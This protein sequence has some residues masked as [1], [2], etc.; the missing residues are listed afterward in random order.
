MNEKLIGELIAYRAK[1]FKENAQSAENVFKFFLDVLLRHSE[2]R[3]E[4][5]LSYYLDGKLKISHDMREISKTIN[6]VVF[7]QKLVDQL[8][9]IAF[10]YGL[11]CW[12][13]VS[14]DDETAIVWFGISEKKP[15]RGKLDRHERL[16][17]PTC[18]KINDD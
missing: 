16:T 4:I 3:G 2:K 6:K 17:C 5:R 12:L 13:Y 11:R 7:N 14:D 1:L 9:Q 10:S 15:F 8:D 18:R